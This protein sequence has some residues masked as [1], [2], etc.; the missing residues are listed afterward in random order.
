PDPGHQH[1][2]VVARTPAGCGLVATSRTK[3][4]TATTAPLRRSTSRS[5]LALI[6]SRTS[7]VTSPS[8]ERRR[9]QLLAATAP[10]ADAAARSRPLYT[11][12]A[13]SR[14]APSP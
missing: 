7:V 2:P 9:T 13:A 8:R 1:P 11:G 12:V 14:P 4:A 3:K 6:A 10:M 5:E